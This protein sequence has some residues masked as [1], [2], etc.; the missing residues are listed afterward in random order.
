MDDVTYSFHPD[1]DPEVNAIA[2]IT[3]ITQQIPVDAAIR[4]LGVVLER[5]K[6][7]QAA[8]PF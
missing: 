7:D 5:R 2:L 1:A 6:A 3:G 4:V 8:V